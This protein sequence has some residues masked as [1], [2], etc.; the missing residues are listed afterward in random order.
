MLR[1]KV[2]LWWGIGLTVAAAVLQWVV[3]LFFYGSY[4][5]AN[6]VDQGMLFVLQTT[7]QILNVTLPVIGA[8]LISAG[9]VMAYLARLIERAPEHS[10][11][12]SSTDDQR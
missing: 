9:I 10:F 3:P 11:R 1:P 6:G 2:V 7:G 12:L 8:A 5:Q 4:A